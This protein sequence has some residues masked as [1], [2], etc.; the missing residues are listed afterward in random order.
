MNTTANIKKN[1]DS[2]A[3]IS[4]AIF[5]LGY[6]L[7]KRNFAE[8]H[9]QLSFLDFPIFVG[10]VLTFICLVLYLVRYYV[11]PFKLKKWHF[12]VIGYAV[13]VLSKT[14][15]GYIQYGPLACRHAAMFYY[16]FF[17]LFGY[18]FYRTDFFEPSKK[19]IALC[20]L[21]F[22]FITWKFDHFAVLTAFVIGIILV[23][24]IP[25]KPWR[26]FF[27][28]IL[29]FVTPYKLFFVTARTIIL[30]NLIGGLFLVVGVLIASKL[31]KRRKYLVAF[32]AL[33]LMIVGLSFTAE[34]TA[35]TSIIKV[36]GLFD[37]YK[38]NK[39]V[40][41]KKKENFQLAKRETVKLFNPDSQLIDA[42]RITL[43]EFKFLTNKG[44]STGAG[45]NIPLSFLEK[46]RDS[47]RNVDVAMNNALFRIFIWQDM[48]DEMIKNN[49]VLGMSFGHP[50]RSEKVEILR[51]GIGEW[52]RDGWIAVHNSFIHMMY[53]A[54]VIGVVMVGLL[55]FGLLKM[56]FM[57]LR[58]KSITGVLLCGALI[59]WFVA[60]NFLIIFELPYNSI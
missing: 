31:Q 10:E 33:S 37:K 22:T 16:P 34:Y 60:A 57:F 47:K 24:S 46:P 11:A 48:Y 50:I 35:A 30:S 7:F 4:I 41:N 49:S 20:V 12:V 28:I 40:I 56:I 39:V 29:L 3:L 5:S 6:F 58:F 36:R 8:L 54:G 21:L 19:M 26:I 13:F 25:S 9:I 42:Y 15:Y 38:F 59:S 2:A 32:S 27:T 17:I 53:R 52:T 14:I 1:I 23:K 18:S 45:I 43:P 51:W 44:L 55:V